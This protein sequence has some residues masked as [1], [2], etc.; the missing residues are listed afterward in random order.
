MQN[1]V[2]YGI[3]VI[4]NYQDEDEKE[5]FILNSAGL[6]SLPENQFPEIIPLDS[7]IKVTL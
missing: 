1:E 3:F 6:F 4:E 5:N 7:L 2:I